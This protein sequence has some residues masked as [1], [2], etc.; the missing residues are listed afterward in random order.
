MKKFFRQMNRTLRIILIMCAIAV[1]SVALYILLDKIL[2]NFKSIEPEVYYE[3]PS[4]SR[5]I[6]L[7]DQI[8]AD[9]LPPA[10]KN[11]AAYIPVDFIKQYFDEYIFW[12]AARAKLTITTA[13]KV[14]RMKTDEL[15]YYVNN[16]P[17]TLDLPIYNIEGEPYMPADLAGTLYSLETRREEEHDLLIV[18]DLGAELVTAKILKK[19]VM[20]Y[21]PDKKSPIAYRLGRDETVAVFGGEGPWVRVRA[22]NGLVGFVQEKYIGERSIREPIKDSGA[23][24][25]PGPT[26]EFTGK[27]RLLW[28]QVFNADANLQ[29]FRRERVKGVDVLSPT[30]F[31]FDKEALNGDIINIAD[32]SYVDWAHSEG[33]KVWALIADETREVSEAVL[34]DTD[35]REHVIRQLLIF[36]AMY[37]LDGI[38]VDFERVTAETAPYFL[39]FLRELKPLLAQAGVVLSVDLYVP[40]YTRYYNRREIAKAVDYACVMTYDEH[41]LQDG[42]G[43]V[44]SLPFVEQGIRDTLEE[45]PKE[46]VLMGIPFYVRIWREEFRDGQTELSLR[47]RGMAAARQQFEENG[48][49]FIWQENA[50]AYYGEYSAEE[51]GVQV[52]YKVWLEDERSITEKL[53]LFHSY[54]LAGIAC[55]KRGLEKDEIWDVI[56]SSF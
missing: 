22:S 31:L 38:N 35:V 52:T 1:V 7:G 25:V 14:I 56:D 9:G 48:A 19:T 4:G 27:I 44:A 55:W 15:T 29:D 11:E 53:R 20:R 47:N 40:L 43:P 2:P 50:G 49:E 16:N 17:L 18:D 41:T 13:D 12:D 8:L 34:T 37:G 54:D 24:L 5:H 28:D 36:T 39:Q 32:K 45:I 26:A 6:T 33:Y 42:V 10:F 21:D 3:W 46:K 23:G 30:W 51:D